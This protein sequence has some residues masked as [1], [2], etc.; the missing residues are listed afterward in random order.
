MDEERGLM[1]RVARGVGVGSAGQGIGQ[2][3]GQPR[4]VAV[5]ELALQRDGGRRHHH[6]FVGGE[7]PRD[8]GHQIGERLAGAGACLHGEVLT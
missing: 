5:D 4:Q 1:E 8:C 7:R 2:R 3:V 6:G